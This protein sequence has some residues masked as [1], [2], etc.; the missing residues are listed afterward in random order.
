VPHRCTREQARGRVPIVGEESAARRRIPSRIR[1]TAPKTNGRDRRRLRDRE[2]GQRGQRDRRG[3]SHAHDWQGDALSEPKNDCRAENT[4]AKI[5]GLF[6]ADALDCPGTE[7]RVAINPPVP[8]ATR[9]NTMPAK[10]RMAASRFAREVLT[11]GQA[12]H[13]QIAAP[14]AP[15]M[16]QVWRR[17][18]TSTTGVQRNI[19][20]GG[21]WS[22]AE[23]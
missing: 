10:N 14:A 19:R 15:S 18:L 23:M 13:M 9:A 21:I 5:T 3:K 20:M 22:S 7:S 2:R 8:V 4:T 11:S 12:S 1:E 6:Q 16:S 17:S